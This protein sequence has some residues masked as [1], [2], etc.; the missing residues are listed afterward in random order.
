MKKKLLSILVSFMMIFNLFTPFASYA[1][2]TTETDP[3]ENY[4]VFDVEKF[5]LGLGYVQEPILVP[6]EKGENCAQ[7]LASVL[8]EDNI[9]YTGSLTSGFYLSRLADE[10]DTEIDGYSKGRTKDGWLGEFDYTQ[11]SGWMYCVNSTFPN[12]GMSSYNPKNGDVMR[13]QFTANGY[14]ADVGGGFGTSAKV[15]NKDKL[16]TA[17][18]NINSATNKN[19]LLSYK[20]IRA[21]YKKANDVMS[22]IGASQSDVDSATTE[23]NEAVANVESDTSATPLT[24][25]TL[26]QQSKEM[27]VGET[28]QL[29][30]TITPSD[31]TDDKT[32]TWKTSKSAIATVDDKGLVTA[33]GEG[34]CKIYAYAG[35]YRATFEVTTKKEDESKDFVIEDGVLKQYNGTKEE[36]TIP[37]TVTSIADGIFKSNKTIKK[38]TIPDTVTSMGDSVFAY[39]TSLTSANI[40]NG[41]TTIPKE[42]FRGCSALKDV[43]I[44]E[45]ITIIGSNAFCAC[46]ALKSVKLPSKLTTIESSAFYHSALNKFDIPDS[47]TSIGSYAFT[48]CK[49]SGEI[50]LPSSLKTIS[51]GAFSSCIYLKTV[52]IPASVD[53]IEGEAFKNCPFLVSIKV[54]DK[55][56]EDEN[57]I[58]LSNVTTLQD[59]VFYDDKTIEKVLLNDNLATI[60]GQTFYNCTSL[61]EIEL[62]KGLTEIKTKAFYNCQNLKTLTL[63]KSVKTVASDITANA[64][65]L[66]DIFVEEGNENYQDSNGVLFTKAG[67]LVIY[68]Q[69]KTTETFV[70]PEGA[71]SLSTIKNDYVKK[72]VIPTSVKTVYGNPYSNCPNLESIEVIEGNANLKAVDGVLYTVSGDTVQKLVSYPSNKQGE[73][74]TVLE[75]CVGMM[76]DA[77]STTVN[78]KTIT[79][80]TTLEKI[81]YG[82][83]GSKSSVTTINVPNGV[84]KIPNNIFSD[85]SSIKNINLPESIESIGN[86]AF[87]SCSSLESITIPKGVKSIGNIAFAYCYKLK[88]VKVYS[89]DVT[90]GNNCF[91]STD[92]NITFYGYPKSTIEE[93]AKANNKN[94]VAFDAVTV[95]FDADNGEDV[96]EKTLLTGK[97]VLDYTPQAPTKEGYTFVGWYKDTD[98][99]TTEYKTGLTYTEDVTYKAKYA[100]VTMLGAQGKLVSDGKSGIRFGTKIY[101]DGDEII[102]KGTLILPVSFLNEGE[103]LR[104]DTPKVAKSVGKVN[105]EVN[106]DENYVTYLGTIINIPEAQF[107]RQMT[108]AAYVIYKDKAG[109][110]YTVYSQYPNESTS[111]YDLLGNNVDW[112]EVW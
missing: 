19:K 47:V 106:K 99:I 112:N 48:N 52:N 41:L 11:F 50:T 10:D 67:Q 36:I 73:E 64:T 102:E 7:I 108:A 18:A 49:L 54:M 100:H 31:T 60:S 12:V 91:N 2:E 22:V 62:P 74:Y 78:L 45:S 82:S 51:R 3:Q 75:G 97:E 109:N 5:I 33:A 94:F 72:I 24:G 61:K 66:T 55:T 87:N 101:N 28:V 59:G 76:S 86:G 44:P 29:K 70:I 4:I 90:I 98:D 42:T 1:E 104:L 83:I 43:T 105:Y 107:H 32:I 58:D 93:Y 81:G 46:S 17:L 6:F 110:K 80:P 56:Y 39:C 27:T 25:I 69:A 20:N 34:S 15:A 40:P 14:G 53:T 9:T 95:K 30:A 68:P 35:G 38:V 65:S 88:E 84:T 37:D 96:E 79:V 77:L 85:C 8:G 111:V 16:T 63:S 103:G 92:S 23:L 13:V 21:A 89:K 57:V 71:T 26:D